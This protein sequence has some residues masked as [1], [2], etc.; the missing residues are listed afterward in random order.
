MDHKEPSPI[1]Q[2]SLSLARIS[3]GDNHQGANLNMNFNNEPR[4]DSLLLVM[5]Y[6]GLLSLGSLFGAFVLM[7]TS[8]P[9]AYQMAQGSSIFWGGF[10]VLALLAALCVAYGLWGL[11]CV[12]G[13][14]QGRASSRQ[15]TF[16]Y[17]S[18]LAAISF[19][20]MFI[21]PATLDSGSMELNITLGVSA[22]LL[23]ASGLGAWWMTR[24]HIKA[25]FQAS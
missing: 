24:P 21:M 6:C 9:M 1:L 8:I 10:A 23:V 14:W 15:M 2:R 20:S 12:R 22:T 17:L 11:W 19:V 18:L 3:S 7:T 5:V 4:P 13:L 25:H 16:V